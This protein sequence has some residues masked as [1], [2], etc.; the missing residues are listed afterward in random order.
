VSETFWWISNVKAI[1]LRGYTMMLI[2]ANE[3]MV[4][5]TVT[6]N[7]KCLHSFAPWE[8][9]ASTLAQT[10]REVA[11]KLREEGRKGKADVLEKLAKA[12]EN[13]SS[14]YVKEGW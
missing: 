9:L 4:H 13:F 14:E 3:L 10:A 2:T 8:V 1:N 5:I 6:D 7:G 11:Q 12:L